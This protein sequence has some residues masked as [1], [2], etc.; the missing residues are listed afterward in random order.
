MTQKHI[1]DKDFVY[2]PAEKMDQQYLW[3]KFFG[4]QKKPEE[5]INGALEQK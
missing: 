2:T 4:E 5:P 3:R 1:Y